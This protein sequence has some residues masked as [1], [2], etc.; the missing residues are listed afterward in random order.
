VSVG[1]E[2]LVQQIVNGLAVGSIY[3]LIALGLTLIFGVLLIPNFAQ[4]E[5]YMLGGLVTYTL[6]AA[7]L[8]FWLALPV[9]A[10]VAGAVGIAMDRLAFRP[11]RD[12]TGLATMIAAFAASIIIQQLAT[13][14][15]GTEPRT[16]PPPISGAVRT[17]L[18]TLT[19]VQLMIIAA[20]LLI[21]A[22]LWL[23]LNRT[24]LGLAI[25]AVAQNQRAAIL[26][27]LD[28][29]RV[30]TATF[31]IGAATGGLAGGLLSANAPMYP[32]VGSDPVLKA[33]VVL[34]LGGIGNVWGAV[35][36]GLLLGISE[37]LIAGYVS[38]E[39]QDLGAFLI[40]ILVLLVRPHGLLGRAEVER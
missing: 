18:M 33:F 21:W 3:A 40:L 13:F 22:A 12:P 5:L 38:S 36:G 32:T 10:L 25:R 20:L 34:V 31:F 9:A 30:R 7:G 37:I 11:L 1:A 23:I 19:Y 27:G 26:M 24:Q 28:L 14:I 29:S 6:V 2:I 15:W 35:A 8:S 16:T 4:G 39:L 17:P